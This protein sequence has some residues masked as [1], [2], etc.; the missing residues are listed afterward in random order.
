[1]NSPKNIDTI[2]SNYEIVMNIK[3]ARNL[4]KKGIMGKPDPYVQITY[5]KMESKSK[6]V[7][8]S[9]KP[10]W[11]YMETLKISNDSPDNILIEVLDEDIGKDDNMGNLSL[12]VL[13]LIEKQSLVNQ[14]MP[15]SDCMSGEI[16][17]SVETHKI[18]KASKSSTDTT[19]LIE[20]QSLVNQWM[21]LRVFSNK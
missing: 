6:T 16:L 7:K 2:A 13:D 3:K 15:L 11:K 4:Q 20:K 12:S 9:Y 14:W 21:P 5:D 10:E 18:F 19:D 1:M 8:N 17:I